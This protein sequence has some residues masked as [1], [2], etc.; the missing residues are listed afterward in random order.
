MSAAKGLAELFYFTS[1]LKIFLTVK[2][3]KNILV[4]NGKYGLEN[5][6]FRAEIFY[7]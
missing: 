4:L 6:E 1:F 5:T 2:D 3:E 7:I